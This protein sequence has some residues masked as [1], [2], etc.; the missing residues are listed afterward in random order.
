MLR[1]TVAFFESC[2]SWSEEVH[3]KTGTVHYSDVSNSSEA[4]PPNKTVTGLHFP[5]LTNFRQCI[6]G[7]PAKPQ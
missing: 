7:K 4:A 3:K 1:G 5:L 2:I 6:I